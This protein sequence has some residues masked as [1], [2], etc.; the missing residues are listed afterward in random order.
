MARSMGDTSFQKEVIDEAETLTKDLLL[1]LH[2]EQQ[3]LEQRGYSQQQGSDLRQGQ[4]R[5]SSGLMVPISSIEHRI[6][7]DHHE[8]AVLQTLIVLLD[9]A[10]SSKENKFVPF[11]YRTI[12][13]IGIKLIDALFAPDIPQ[14]SKKYI[15]LFSWLTDYASIPGKQFNYFQKLFQEEH[16]KLSPEDRMFFEK[17]LE[18]SRKREHESLFR[19]IKKARTRLGVLIQNKSQGCIRLRFLT[20]IRF[21]QQYSAW[22]HLLH[23]NSLLI[24]EVFYPSMNE[25]EQFRTYNLVLAAGLNAATRVAIYL[26]DSNILSVVQGLTQRYDALWL[27]FVKLWKQK[28]I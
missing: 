24:K 22:S 7:Y 15:K 8:S 12:L 26:D 21:D 27:K 11:S 10:H 18:H 13:D 14:Q 19:T 25:R 16:A 28:I 6:L 3:I 20:G 5:L 4:V 23:G 9:N 1:Y 2:T 17:I